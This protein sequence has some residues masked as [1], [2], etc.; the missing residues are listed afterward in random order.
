MSSEK[1]SKA[2]VFVKKLL[3]NNAVTL[4]FFVICIAGIILADQ[5]MSYIIGEISSR[6]F[7]NLILILAL[8]VPVWAGMGMNF[9][10][11][12]GAMAAQIGII[13]STNFSLSGIAC[14]VVSFLLCITHYQR[15][16]YK[17]GRVF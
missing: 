11:V 8:L 1:T 16:W 4:L 13:V 2:G 12:L 3:I 9:S 14:L 7:R 17:N 15:F 6:L 10:I 5:P